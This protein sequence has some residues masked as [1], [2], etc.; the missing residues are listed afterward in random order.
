M[1]SNHPGKAAIKRKEISLDM[2][3]EKKTRAQ[4]ESRVIFLT[5]ENVNASSTRDLV[6]SFDR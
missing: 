6:L 1:F 2:F 5:T 4:R 3:I